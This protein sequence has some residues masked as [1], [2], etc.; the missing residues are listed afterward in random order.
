MASTLVRLTPT[1]D[2]GAGTDGTIL[3]NAYLQSI[4][5]SLENTFALSTSF[6]PTWGNTGTANSLGNGT[7][8]GHY[9]Q[10]GKFVV[11]RIVLTWGNTTSS[12]N[13]N[14]TLT[15]PVTAGSTNNG[16]GPIS[17]AAL[18]SGSAQYQVQVQLT[19]TTVM[20][21]VTLNA[22]STN[23]FESAIT[24]TSPMTWTTSDALILNGWYIA[25]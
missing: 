11:F 13:G 18:D 17:G 5:D 2:S 24:S 7:L 20:L 1:D 15:L 3:N 4:Y 25:A 10:F 12:G 8:T 6:T 9:F 16:Y 14:W 19:S 23:A 22:A 21:P